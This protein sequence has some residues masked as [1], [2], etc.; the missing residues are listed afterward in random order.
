MGDGGGWS[1]E[2]VSGTMSRNDCD[3]GG[4]ESMSVMVKDEDEDEKNPGQKRG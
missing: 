2:E 1:R 4:Q 3:E